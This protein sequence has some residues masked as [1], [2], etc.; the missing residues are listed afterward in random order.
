MRIF[1]VL[2]LTSILSAHADDIIVV[3]KSKC[4]ESGGLYDGG[5]RCNNG[6]YINP[7]FEKCP[8]TSPSPLKTVPNLNKHTNFLSEDVVERKV[9]T[10]AEFQIIMNELKEASKEPQGCIYN[11]GFTH[12]NPKQHSAV[13]KLYSF[14][15]RNIDVFKSTEDY[16]KSNNLSLNC[17][18]DF[19]SLLGKEKAKQQALT[20]FK[21]IAPGQKSIPFQYEITSL[22][23]NIFQK[24][25][26]NY[27]DDPDFHQYL[28]QK[29]ISKSDSDFDYPTARLGATIGDPKLVDKMEEW[30]SGYKNRSIVGRQLQKTQII[31]VAELTT[32][33]WDYNN[34][35]EARLSTLR[36]TI[37]NDPNI[38]DGAKAVIREFNNRK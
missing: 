7:H 26:I 28:N 25:L 38:P 11:S 23:W 36:M 16:F 2:I 22:H 30:V 9:G 18:P 31:H 13:S 21:S 15:W 29:Y 35:L 34:G 37:L 32:N 8:D 3:F 14:D 4:K 17:L 6:N 5:C 12:H 10:F 19:V 33:F 20:Y 27:R 1:Y 24:V